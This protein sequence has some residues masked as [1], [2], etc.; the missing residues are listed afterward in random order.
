MKLLL[1]L[2]RV[3]NKN[4][5]KN[6]SVVSYNKT[7]TSK[8]DMFYR[9]LIDGK[10]TSDE[11]AFTLLYPGQTEMNPYYKLKHQL[12]E[13]LY[14]TVFFVDLKKSKY[15]NRESALLECQSNVMLA[16][17]L[18][19]FGARENYIK[20]G[21]KVTSVAAKYQFTA[22]HIFGLSVASGVYAMAGQPDKVLSI[23]KEM[24]E[25]QQ[26]L[27]KE[28]VSRS[29]WYH[30]SS[31]Y[32]VDRSKKPEV[33]ALIDE[34][35]A[36]INSMPC[37]LNSGQLTYTT[38]ALHLAKYMSVNEYQEAVPHGEAGLAEI[39][40]LPFPYAS[41]IFA[42]GINLTAC[43]VALKE[44]EKG[45]RTLE[46]VRQH[47]TVGK[48]NW[49]KHLEFSFLLSVHTKR[50]SN[51][52]KVYQQVINHSKFKKL[53]NSIQETW[54]IYSAYLYLLHQSGRLSD[55]TDNN[56]FRIHRYLNSVPTFTKDKRGQNVPIL[57][58]QFILLLQRGDYDGVMDRYEAT[59][60]YRDRYLDKEKNFRANVFFRM[61]AEITKSD[62]N[63]NST[64]RRTKD[65]RAM[66]DEVPVGVLQ[67]SY[68]QEVLPYEDLYDI[69]LEL[70]T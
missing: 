55:W 58:S 54:I 66:L 63:Y 41:A 11:E 53:P 38:C 61:M 7:G 24:K 52:Y 4:K 27:S 14:Q 67:P 34:Y 10:I 68:D 44:F 51:A 2:T 35:L 59:M 16:K 47:I 43:Y 22:E 56:N 8:L 5:T 6:I 70:L 31:M 62:Y 64:K 37:S 19:R 45:E 46:I 18:I 1:E 32:V 60:K 25:L 42:I 13:R 20:L 17:L 39:M 28:S 3:L 50:F 23:N 36:D 48:Y 49:F 69:I 15:D 12:R 40:K 9:A 21:K 33:E 30:I 29:H 65:Y 57:I 26:L